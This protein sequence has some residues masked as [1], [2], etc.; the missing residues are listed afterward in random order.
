MKGASSNEPQRL[1][2]LHV[3]AT[4][5]PSGMEMM[6]LSSAEEWGRLGYQCDIVGPEREIGPL[7]PQLRDA[8]YGI[9]HIPFRGRARYLFRA[10]FFREFYQ[11]SA[12]GYDVLHIHTEAITPIFAVL[13]KLAGIRIISLTPHNVFRFRGLLRVRKYLERW[14]IR[15]LGGRY[16]M[17]S[18]GVQR[19][20]WELYR[21]PGV[22]TW[23]WLDTAKF[24]PPTPEERAAA[25]A[26]IGCKQDQFVLLSVA[27]CN[28][29]KNHNAI[30]RAVALLRATLHCEYLHVGREQSDRQE[31]ALAQELGI[32]A[33]VRF[34]GS[35]SDLMPFFWAA[36][37]FVMP[38]LFEG[39]GISA[40]EAIAAGVPAVL[41]AT[42]GLCDVIAET[43]WS[44][45]TGTSAESVARGLSEL[46]QIPIAERMR[47]AR[48][49]SDLIRK[50]FSMPDGVRS[51]VVGL[52]GATSR[53]D[54][55]Q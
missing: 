10:G 36:D 37:A 8:G 52:Y 39:L 49:D 6:F 38:S 30:L 51:I 20:E 7:A 48:V 32:A 11:L 21:N 4:L 35:Q 16:G 18:E 46:A 55:L 42:E 44:V 50:R 15:R 53:V 19:C 41:A 17:I 5:L 34:L 43:Q 45:T 24:R 29:F 54:E 40:L 47:R 33:Q 28:D 14:F 22:R 3:M 27:N 31:E 9:F 1:R 13:G 26:A 25:R 12:S 2:V 23:N